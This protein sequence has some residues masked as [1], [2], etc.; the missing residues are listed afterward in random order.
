MIDPENVSVAVSSLTLSGHLFREYR[1]GGNPVKLLSQYLF[2]AGADGL[3]LLPFWFLKPEY[4]KIPEFNYERVHVLGNRFLE[5]GFRNY[6]D[7]VLRAPTHNNESLRLIAEDIASFGSFKSSERLHSWMHLKFPYAT[8]VTNVWGNGMSRRVFEIQPTRIGERNGR[9]FL[10]ERDI[11]ERVYRR[12]DFAVNSFLLLY[13][14][15]QAV[16]PPV[17]RKPLEFV[18]ELA[19]LGAVKVF[20]L[21]FPDEL[22]LRSFMEGRSTH[23][24]FLLLKALRDWNSRQLP[25]KPSRATLPIVLEISPRLTAPSVMPYKEL[26]QILLIC[27]K[28]VLDIV[29][30]ACSGRAF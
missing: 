5:G 10:A 9:S 25:L 15:G 14:W 2:D 18:S 28:S 29:G 23:E 21:H 24:R 26:V 27:R 7:R 22:G 1:L 11:M 20:T 30:D 12:R 3:K 8:S 4:F 16:G 6:M 19:S 17:S 13:D